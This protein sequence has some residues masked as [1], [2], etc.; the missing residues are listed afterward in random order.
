[1]SLN[2]EKEIEFSREIENGDGFGWF[3]EARRIE[4]K[5]QCALRKCGG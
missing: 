5:M 1:M 4:K 3:Y 2:R